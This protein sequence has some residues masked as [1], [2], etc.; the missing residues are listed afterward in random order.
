MNR[1]LNLSGVALALALI[2]GCGP[3]VRYQYVMPPSE[4]GRTCVAQCR[5]QQSQCESLARLEWQNENRL[6]EAERRSYHYCSQGKSKQQARKECLAP[7]YSSSFGYTGFGGSGNF[8][9]S[10]DYD[11]CF[12]DICGG[13][14]RRIVEQLQ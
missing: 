5:T 7:G 13:T 11:R 2:S 4:A 6:R 9:C 12:T 10:S 3:S 8:N 1:H 14:I